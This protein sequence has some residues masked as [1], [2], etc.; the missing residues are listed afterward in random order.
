VAQ[1]KAAIGHVAPAA[2]LQLCYGPSRV[3]QQPVTG[4]TYLVLRLPKQM[5]LPIRG[6]VATH[7]RENKARGPTAEIAQ[8]SWSRA[9]SAD[10]LWTRTPRSRVSQPGDCL[11]K[12]FYAEPTR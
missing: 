7:S 12:A 9:L 2:E 5:V 8:K 11:P 4:T 3:R 1:N 10:E 6:V